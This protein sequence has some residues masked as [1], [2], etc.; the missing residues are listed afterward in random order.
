ML[1]AKRSCRTHVK[2]G[3]DDADADALSCPD[4]PCVVCAVHSHLVC[5]PADVEVVRSARH[6]PRALHG[7]GVE[8][9]RHLG[10]ITGDDLCVWG[11]AGG[12][13]QQS[14]NPK[15]HQTIRRVQVCQTE[16][17]SAR[18]AQLQ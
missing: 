10:L 14:A 3:V 7:Q 4:K 5:V 12:K 8:H 13:K 18:L 6:D 9:L 16:I 2:S 17:L 1:T 11:G 15:N